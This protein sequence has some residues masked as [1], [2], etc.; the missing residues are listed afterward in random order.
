MNRGVLR[1]AILGL[2][3]Y[4]LWLSGGASSVAG[5]TGNVRGYVISS[6]YRLPDGK[7]H[8]YN[9]SDW[10]DF[11]G[12]PFVEVELFSPGTGP[13]RR[14]ADNS[15]FFA[16]LALPPGRYILFVYGQTDQF[17]PVSSHCA[18]PADVRADQSTRA[19]VY[20][21]HT[22]FIDVLC[23]RTRINGFG[24][25]FDMNQPLDVY[26]FNEFARDWPQLIES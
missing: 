26:E 10:N 8:F 22:E 6:D 21:D 11:H 1:K 25:L 14:R 3:L 20:V 5:T 15:G 24:N 19:D 23:R 16:F 4:A 2:G 18:Y 9:Y 7:F 12:A 17:G 13:V